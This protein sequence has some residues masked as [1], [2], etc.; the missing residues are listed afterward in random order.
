MNILVTGGN[1]FL[2]DSFLRFLLARNDVNN[3]V[4]ID[5]LT[6]SAIV[7]DN[8]QNSNRLHNYT[9]DINDR[10]FISNLLRNYKITHVVNFAST[11]DETTL[12]HTNINGVYNLMQACID[13]DV[14]RFHTISTDKIY[15][16]Q[17]QNEIEL[18]HE[19]LPYNTNVLADASKAAAVRIALAHGNEKS[20]PT[21]VSVCSNIYGPR[22][23]VD[24][25][26]P[27]TI[28]TIKNNYKIVLNNSGNNI[29]DWLYVDDH[30]DAVFK[31]ITNNNTVNQ[32]INICTGIPTSDIE[33]IEIIANS[34]N[35]DF[36]DSYTLTNNIDGYR[37]CG[38]NTKIQKL[39]EWSPSVSLRDGISKAIEYYSTI[40]SCS[41]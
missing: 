34:L 19:N 29:R 15:G 22:Q 1:G 33:I 16:Y 8:V 35:A 41:I 39:T 37:F 12:I 24:K 30:S 11:T 5:K 26:I 6:K 14:L 40:E 32:I 18:L 27:K 20:I 25:L 2:G 9:F 10:D 13:N 23:S 21:S 17:P 28:L 7:T 36:T 4:N 31:I 38:D 3:I